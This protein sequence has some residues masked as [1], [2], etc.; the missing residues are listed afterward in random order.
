MV[1]R[2]GASAVSGS[3]S[4]EP[5]RFVFPVRVEVTANT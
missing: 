4:G 2:V 3:P 1:V 5:P